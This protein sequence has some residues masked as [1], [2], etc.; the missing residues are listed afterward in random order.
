MDEQAVTDSRKTL[1][2]A[3]QLNAMSSTDYYKEWLL[4][5]NYMIDGLH[6]S[7]VMVQTN[8]ILLNVASWQENSSNFSRLEALASQLSHWDQPQISTLESD[9]NNNE[10]F[11]L[12]YPVKSNDDSSNNNSPNKNRPIALVAIALQANSQEALQKAMATLQWSTAGLEVIDYQH[13]FEALNFEQKCTA[14]RVNILTRVLAEPDY[15]AAAMGLVTELATL[16]NCDR[17]SL[18]E[19]DNH[20]ATL[21][22]LSH[23]T[24]FGKK[25]NLVR[26]IE[27]VM[28]ESIDQG[29]PVRFPQKEESASMLILAHRK[30]SELQ[31]DASILSIPVYSEQNVTGAIVLETSPAKPFTDKQVEL[32]QS[33]ISLVS[34]SLNDKRLNDRSLWRKAAD[35][36][37]TQLKRFTGPN[38]PGR[39]LTAL[40]LIILSLF[41]TFATGTYRLSTQARI[42]SSAQRAIVAPYDGYIES[43]HA[44]AGDTVSTGD[45]LISLDDRDL[46][47]EKLKWLSEQAKLNRQ[48]QEA[49]AFRDRAKINIINA[50]LQ[51]AEAQLALV[52]TQLERANLTAPFDGLVVSGD[53]DQRLGSSISK[54][55]IL[56]SVS[57]LDQ[58]RIKMLVQENR[59][60]DTHIGQNGTLHLS[61]LPETPFDFRL[62]KI[63]PLTE[64]LDGSTYFIVEG[65]LL[66]DTSQ[67]Q[68]GMEGIG[69]I[70]IDERNLLGIWLRQTREWLQLKLWTWWG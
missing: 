68:P 49:L 59:I 51:Q 70:T 8:N 66:S 21:K 29:S 69:K 60:A 2:N 9:G 47:L 50:Q 13:R 17:V 42:E 45:L 61:A 36:G 48:Y 54:G 37:K 56:L 3:S 10:T 23:N 52:N 64:A 30:L 67:I 41:F 33:I 43:T 11:A 31:G 65:E 1:N 55:E 4:G 39:K 46:R 58:Y 16:L 28:D 7:L 27:Q 22:Y 19:Y 14:D 53:L 57:E 15:P 38:Y 35:S 5:Q 62:S 40:I 12:L 44:R 18:G 63:T 25:M 24:Q 6:C 26:A 34:P 20:H 32:C